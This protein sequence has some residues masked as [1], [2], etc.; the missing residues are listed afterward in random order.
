MELCDLGRDSR[1]G[2]GIGALLSKQ[3]GLPLD[4]GLP[5]NSL[6]LFDRGFRLGFLSCERL[7]LRSRLL[8]QSDGMGESSDGASLLGGIICQP[9]YLGSF[10]LAALVVW[11]GP[12][13]W[14]W[15]RVLNSGKVAVLIALLWLSIIV[16]T[17]QAY[18][19]FI[20]FIF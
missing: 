16:M 12:Q 20:Y 10:L 9:Y 14:D 13:T 17:T 11:M 1:D 18:N 4:S 6:H 5:S 7:A 3:R 2:I 15:T 8:S 19:P